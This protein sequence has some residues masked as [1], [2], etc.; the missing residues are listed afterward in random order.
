MS[1]LREGL[2]AARLIVGLVLIAGC[3]PLDHYDITINNVSVYQ[4]EPPLQ[5]EG[6][7]DPALHACIEQTALDL[8]ATEVESLEQLNCSNAGIVSLAGLERLN[9]IQSL[10][11]SGNDI[12][13][14][15]T[16]ERL[17]A[18]QQLWL[19]SNDIVDPI[20]VL[21]LPALRHLDLTDNPRLQCPAREK[22]PS[23]MQLSLP[24]HC[25]AT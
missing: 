2:T 8:Q 12:R 15:L 5:V 4:P 1:Q 19:D 9:G 11:L 18:L 10:K 22:I 17:P 14:L 7:E 13:N 16:L 24:D 21:R 3:T 23:S 6:I 25:K 20:P